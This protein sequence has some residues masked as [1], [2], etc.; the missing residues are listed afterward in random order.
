LHVRLNR[1][2]FGKITNAFWT[3]VRFETN[4]TFRTFARTML[5]AVWPLVIQPGPW[6]GH[7][8]KRHKN[9]L[10]GAGGDRNF[11]IFSGTCRR[12]CRLSA[13]VIKCEQ[14]IVL[15]RREHAEEKHPVYRPDGQKHRSN[16]ASYH[17]LYSVSQKRDRHGLILPVNFAKYWLKFQNSFPD[18][19]SNTDYGICRWKNWDKKITYF[20]QI[21]SAFM[22]TQFFS[23]PEHGPPCKNFPLISFERDAKLGCCVSYRIG[24]IRCWGLLLLRLLGIWSGCVHTQKNWPLAFRFSRT[25]EVIGTNTDRS[26]TYDFLLVIRSNR[27][28]NSYRF[29]DKRR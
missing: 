24:I 1:F 26:A 20:K 15:K 14:R 23:R 4:K 5:D 27:G 29:R 17:Y 12:H 28:T 3:H 25:L 6:W 21:A 8:A 2:T 18:R 13:T 9:V 7:D 11:L 10:S 19:L 22:S 16:N